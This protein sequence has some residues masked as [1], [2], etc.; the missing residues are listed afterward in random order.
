MTEAGLEPEIWPAAG[1]AAV[2]LVTVAVASRAPVAA[3]PG[4]GAAPER[5]W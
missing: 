2:Q 4:P 1:V 5:I 3:L